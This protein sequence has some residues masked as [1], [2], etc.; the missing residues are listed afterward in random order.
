[1]IEEEKEI[2][3]PDNAYTELKEGEKYKPILL[4]D[5]KYPE[6]NLWT[7]LWGILMA[8]IFSA[9]TAYSGL[10]FGQVFEAA[11][12]IAIIAVSIQRLKRRAAFGKCDYQIISSTRSDC[13]GSISPYLLSILSRKI[14]II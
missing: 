1:M 6:V 7:V 10:R 5:K 8:V 12:P 2:K 9:A 11:I 4:P 14:L 13:N 3:L